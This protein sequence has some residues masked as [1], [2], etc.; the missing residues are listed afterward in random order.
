MGDRLGIPSAVDFF[1]PMVRPTF[2]DTLFPV[3]H[4]HPVLSPAL[5]II[6]VIS[7]Y[8][9]GNYLYFVYLQRLSM[10]LAYLSR[11]I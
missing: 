1:L 10:K 8:K 11:E 2:D 6:I 9:Y 4:P 3:T 7:I 5:V